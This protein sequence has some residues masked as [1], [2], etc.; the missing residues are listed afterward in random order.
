MS[1]ITVSQDTFESVIS[2]PGIVF[3]DFWAKWCRPCRGFAPIYEKAAE[4]HPDI[5]FGTVDTEKEPALQAQLQIMAIPTLMGFRDGILLF[6][7]SGAMPAAVF[8]DVIRQVQALDM[9]KVR[10][11]LD[12]PDESDEPEELK[13]PE[14]LREA[15]QTEDLD[16][17][18]EGMT[19]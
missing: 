6:S 2:L 3:L 12:Q 10:A 18:D 19:D 11:E 8:E 1:V 13:E 9:D 4:A 7:Q 17:A 5:F 14:E 15:E 16:D